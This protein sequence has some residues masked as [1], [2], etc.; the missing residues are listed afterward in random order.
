MIDFTKFGLAPEDTAATLIR[1]MRADQFTA[2]QDRASPAQKGWVTGG[3]ASPGNAICFVGAD[4]AINFAIGIIGGHA[5][6]DAA[7]IATAL[8]TAIW[9]LSNDDGSLSADTIEN[10]TL[11]WGLSQYRFDHYRPTK[12]GPRTGF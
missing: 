11:G 12:A 4:G 10:L 7:K 8:P 2:W 9:Q 1:P 3:F 5:I 6:W